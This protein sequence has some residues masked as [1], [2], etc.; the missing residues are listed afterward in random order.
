VEGD[1]LPVLV[2]RGGISVLAGVWIVVPALF[3]IT[4]GLA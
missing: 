3:S 4:E 1:E 2:A